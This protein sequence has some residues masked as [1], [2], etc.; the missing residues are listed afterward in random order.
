ML[1]ELFLLAFDTES[2]RA[3][4]VIVTWHCLLLQCRCVLRKNCLI[5]RHF[6]GVWIG[7]GGPG[8]FVLFLKYTPVKV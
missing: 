8:V 3:S 7:T 5:S 2:P 1:V 6:W 4:S